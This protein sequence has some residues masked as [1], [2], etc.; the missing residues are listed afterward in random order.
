M[1]TPDTP[2]DP[3]SD[4]TATPAPYPAPR[5]E[6]GRLHVYVSVGHQQMMT[7]AMRPFGRSLWQMVALRPMHAAGGRLFV[8]VTDAL[9]SPPMRVG[10]ISALGKAD[11]LIGDALTS[12]VDEGLVPLAAGAAAPAPVFPAAEPLDPDPDLVAALIAE[13][14]ASVAALADDLAG[15]L[16]A[17][18]IDAIEAD[19]A[20]LQR[21]LA[22]P[23]SMRV[24]TTA[25]DATAWLN[26]HVAEWL[27]IVNIADVLTRSAPGNVTSEMGLALLDVADTVR[28]H[29]DVVVLLRQADDSFL[30]QLDPLPGGAEVRRAIE[31]FL[32]RYGARCVGEIDI[33]RTR[34]AERPSTLLPVILGHVD[35]ESPGEA[36]RRYEEGRLAALTEERSLLERLRARPDGDAR[37]A[38][39]AQMIERVRTFIGYREYPKYG[40]VRRLWCYKQAVLRELDRLVADGA[41]RRVDDAWFLTFDELGEAVRTGAVDRSLVDLRREEHLAYERL[42]PP[43]VLTSDGRGWNGVYRRGDVPSGALAG[44]AVSSGTVD[45]RARVVLDLDDVELEPGDILVTTGTDPSWTPLF[46]AAAALVTEV[47]GLMTHGAVVAREYG[48]PAVVG[49]HDATRRIPDRSRIRVDG[50]HGV[51]H[52]LDG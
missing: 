52:L 25:M 21:L 8:D 42:V 14:E 38:D 9:A 2:H 15:R 49:V 16:G 32:E 35:H 10:M 5:S 23:R 29:A 48:L 39:T 44:L 19:I 22:D 20:E 3:A 12:V 40:I 27:G 6:D 50:T 4:P 24:L 1:T 17:D 30:L 51:V 45:G 43:R 34:W 11:P 41:L 46:V 13:N 36:Q 18:V 37:A 33:T 28:P 26:E 7:D 47:G 31:T